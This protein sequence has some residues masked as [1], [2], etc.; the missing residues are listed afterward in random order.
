MLLILARGCS[1]GKVGTLCGQDPGLDSRHQRWGG[2]E[3]KDFV[4]CS[5]L[6]DSHIVVRC[7]KCM[8]GSYTCWGSGQ[9]GHTGLQGL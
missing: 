5:K 3:N 9:L 2:G 1:S 6:G 8:A 7:S 4:L